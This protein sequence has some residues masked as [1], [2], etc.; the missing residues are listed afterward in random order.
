MDYS[1]ALL[2]RAYA[3]SDDAVAI[4]DCPTE[5]VTRVVSLPSSPLN[6]TPALEL[7]RIY[8]LFR[9]NNEIAGLNCIADSID[10]LIPT[11][12]FPELLDYVPGHRLLY[13]SE[14]IEERPLVV[15]DV[16]SRQRVAELMLGCLPAQVCY[17][18]NYD[19]V[20]V[21]SQYGDTLVF[22]DCSTHTVQGQLFLPDG[23]AKMIYDP[24]NQLLYV[25]TY[26]DVLIVV[27]PAVIDT[28]PCDYSI[29]WALDYIGNKLYCSSD[30]RRLLIV[31]C[32]VNRLGA[33]IQ[34]PRL[35][36]VFA[37]SPVNRRMF[38]AMPYFSG[39]ASG[40]HFIV[41]SNRQEQTTIR[42][43]IIVR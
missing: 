4:I 39:L 33:E 13:F 37:F 14:G 36:T 43:L 30:L 40:V 1:C 41:S 20:A 6:P 9:D 11:E 21:R 24:V 18:Q 35:V 16:T 28:I 12:S 7:N 31:D 15:Y 23:S 10:E 5:S 42:R 22:V 3:F 19:L 32:R 26:R 25:A 17:L 29:T 2:N 8:I 27:D 38:A 34:L